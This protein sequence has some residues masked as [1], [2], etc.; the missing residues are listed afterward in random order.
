[1]G[2]LKEVFSFSVRVRKAVMQGLMLFI[3]R[4]TTVTRLAPTSMHR[5][6]LQMLRQTLAAASCSWLRIRTTTRPR[7][8]NARPLQMRFI[9][10]HRT[11]HTSMTCEFILVAKPLNHKHPWGGCYT[12]TLG[13]GQATFTQ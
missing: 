12:D 2:G 9:A 13:R 6:S 11:D 7:A 8:L 10:V 3:V 5:G 4:S 1:M